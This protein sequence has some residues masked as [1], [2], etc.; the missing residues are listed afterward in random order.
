[1]AINKKTSN[2]VRLD[3]SQGRNIKSMDFKIIRLKNNNLKV[4]IKWKSADLFEL[5]QWKIIVNPEKWN[6][7]SIHYWERGI[8]FTQTK[9]EK[10]WDKIKAN[11]KGR[12]QNRKEDKYK[13]LLEQ[14]VKVF[15]NMR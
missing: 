3:I 13:Q 1:M 8:T 6:H 9:Y 7:I 4:F 5:F 14:I 11:R 12:K 15:E 10:E 2:E